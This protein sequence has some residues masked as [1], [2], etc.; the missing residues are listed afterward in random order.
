MGRPQ[1]G[2]NPP[3]GRSS[4][5][6]MNRYVRPPQFFHT[7][8]VLA[9]VLIFWNPLALLAQ[10]VTGLTWADRR[11]NMEAGYAEAVVGTNSGRSDIYVIASTAGGV[12]S[13]A[14]SSNGLGWQQGAVEPNPD[15]KSEFVSD[16]A[17]VEGPGVGNRTWAAVG[18]SGL[19]LL[20]HDNAQT[21]QRQPPVLDGL[22]NF[23]GIA[24]G[25]G[26]LLASGRGWKPDEQ[27]GGT[28]GGAVWISRDRGLTWEQSNVDTERGLTNPL[29]FNGVWVVAG[30]GGVI[31]RSVDEGE[32]WEVIQGR[33]TGG[34]HSIAGGN[35]TIMLIGALG[36]GTV[37]ERSVDGGETWG[38]VFGP[39]AGWVT[40]VAFGN[41]RFVLSGGSEAQSG[42]MSF[43]GQTWIP[44]RGDSGAW[45]TLG[46]GPK[47]FLAVGGTYGRMSTVANPPSITPESA[48]ETIYGKLGR[49][50]RRPLKSK[51]AG[52]TFL[53][54]GL[55]PGLKLASGGNFT[56]RPTQAGNYQVFLYA[57][58]GG[59]A[60]DVRTVLLSITDPDGPGGAA[61]AWQR[62]PSGLAGLGY[63]AE[64]TA[65]SG[66]GFVSVGANATGYAMGVRSTDG[67]AWVPCNLPIVSSE[68]D[69]GRL[70]AVAGAGNLWLVAGKEGL[71][72][73]SQNGGGNW[74]ALPSPG[75]N[76][77]A[78]S[79]LATDGTRFLLVGQ[80]AR[81]GGG[82]GAAAFYS[83]DGG[84]TWLELDFAEFPPFRLAAFSGGRWWIG[85][86][87]GV[88]LR[89]G[90]ITEA[91][92][93]VSPPS[94]QD[95]RA[96]S[97]HGSVVVAALAGGGVYRSLD[98]AD[99]WQKGA[100]GSGFW[101]LNLVNYEGL[102]VLSGGDKA[103]G[104]SSRD[105]LT[106]QLPASGGAYGPIALATNA[107]QVRFVSLNGEEVWEAAGPWVP[108]VLQPMSPPVFL[109]GQALDY[110]IL[111]AGN[112]TG[113]TVTGLPSGL[114]F[115]NDSQ[116]VVGS[117]RRIGTA[118]VSFS[119]SNSAGVSNTTRIRFTFET[120]FPIA[121]GSYQAVAA[122]DVLNAG[123]GGSVQFQVNRTGAVSGRAWLGLTSYPFRGL[124]DADGVGTVLLSSG[125]GH[126]INLEL[127]VGMEE[128]NAG[129][130]E[131]TI[132]QDAEA[133]SLSGFRNGW[134]ARKNPATAWTGTYHAGF[135]AEDPAGQAPQG[136]GFAH[137]TIGLNGRIQVSGRMAD[138]SSLTWAGFLSPTGR[139][140]MQARF[141]RNAALSSRIPVDPSLAGKPLL[142]TARWTKLP[143]GTNPGFQTDLPVRGSLYAKP[144]G[145][146]MLWGLP[147]EEGN[148]VFLRS[149]ESGLAVT[150]LP[151]NRTSLPA[152]TSL[153]ALVLKT[154]PGTWNGSF[155]YSPGKRTSFRGR[156]LTTPWNVAVGYALPPEGSAAVQLEPA[157]VE[158][159]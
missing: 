125:S 63:G 32:T 130:F 81:L 102:F 17:L 143:Q 59:F 118:M 10:N 144:T 134:Q 140:E 103:A 62:Y 136:S 38:V 22:A 120:P 96:L 21:W 70:R 88:I 5:T 40:G 114:F 157:T 52:A 156:I 47:G 1:G 64:N 9:G 12:P 117:T 106:W 100:A 132:T 148:A 30:E 129:T 41:G 133:T 155:E 66:N 54:V 18:P 131:G 43:N 86:Q 79:G 71:L 85:G 31:A 93:D 8:L 90:E 35:G 45:G 111:A 44:A 72:L 105:G 65:F 50:L 11:V 26:V 46:F 73:R 36:G 110:P 58:R 94:V 145:G 23:I 158:E 119:A 82:D 112:P 25:E 3:V 109:I 154:G 61:L 135:W 121:V 80:K 24:G 13:F 15:G 74:A 2:D 51:P 75:G 37:I 69:W 91:W 108:G 152:D 107:G 14:W 77:T 149:G 84:D 20:S 147:E 139:W 146:A 115:L 137:M 113:W 128:P 104:S 101:P 6:T 123:M 42:A 138:G 7:L 56:G 151:K 97:A 34:Y 92:E 60:G 39:E 116:T 29:I 67:R 68:Y 4:H 159:P 78:Y 95:V 126:P 99:S 127:S 76:A 98:G 33:A 153:K 28:V 27:G 49:P 48:P 16:L 53:A 57:L 122:P 83:E 55:P 142:G 124:L 150:V 19:L 87:E 89:A 141:G